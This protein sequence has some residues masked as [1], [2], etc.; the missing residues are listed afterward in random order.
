MSEIFEF[1]A[2]MAKMAKTWKPWAEKIAKAAKQTLGSCEVYIFGSTVKGVQTG[3]SDV[4]ILIVTDRQI[5]SNK[6]RAQLKAAIEEKAGLP[7]IH[8]FEIHLTTR[9]EAKWY[10]KHIKNSYIKIL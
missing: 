3:G 10:W 9:S 6:E 2:E 5:K 7:P 4:D 8:P 1:K